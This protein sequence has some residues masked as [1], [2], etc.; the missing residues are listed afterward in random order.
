M[1]TR[2][3]EGLAVR[4]Q[5]IL[6]DITRALKLIKLAE[7]IMRGSFMCLMLSVVFT[8]CAS[9]YADLPEWAP[10]GLLWEVIVLLAVLIFT[11]LWRISMVWWLGYLQE[12]EEALDLILDPQNSNE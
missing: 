7:R 4:Y 3:N 6:R 8:M 1:P 11:A 10:M 5:E 2:P 9:A 12:E